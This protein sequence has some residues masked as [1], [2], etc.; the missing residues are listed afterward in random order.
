MPYVKSK[1]I[2]GTVNK[3]LAYI[4]DAKKTDGMLLTT[5]INCTTDAHDAYLQMKM[6]YEFYTRRSYNESIKKSGKWQA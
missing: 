2:H 5:S 1:P 4:L 3:S 6:I